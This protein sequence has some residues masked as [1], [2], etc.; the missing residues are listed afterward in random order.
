[1][2]KTGASIR[3]DRIFEPNPHEILPAPAFCR[4]PGCYKLEIFLP[5]FGLPAIPYGCKPS[6]GSVTK[7][8]QNRLP[9]I[10]FPQSN[11]HNVSP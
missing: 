8:P 5:S 4:Q 10:I 11:R 6:G 2:Q 3:A 1:M 9:V 7:L